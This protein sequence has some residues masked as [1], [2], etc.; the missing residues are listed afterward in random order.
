MVGELTGERLKPLASFVMDWGEWLEL[1]P[2]TKILS[3][4]Q[5]LGGQT[6]RYLR[7]PFSSY[8]EYLN[9][10]DNRYPFPVDESLVGNRLRP[11]EIVVA[12]SINDIERGYPPGLIG[13]AAIN[14][15]I[16]GIPIVVFS[17]GDRQ[18]AT[19]FSPVLESDSRRL[20]FEFE[21]GS[22]KDL[23]TGTV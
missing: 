8:A 3:R 10:G 17:R 14:D 23:Q 6:D 15:Q 2:T 12:V 11:S 5:G 18:I 19:V 20:E 9:A 7:D 21:N 22:Y 13:K 1:H 4:D 16:D